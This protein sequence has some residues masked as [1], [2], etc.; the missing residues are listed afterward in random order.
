L[1][2]ARIPRCIRDRFLRDDPFRQCVHDFQI[3]PPEERDLYGVAV[4][5]RIGLAE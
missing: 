4:E 3:H 1:K 5:V 2:P